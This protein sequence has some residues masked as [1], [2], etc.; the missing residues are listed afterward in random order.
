MPSNFVERQQLQF[1]NAI[2]PDFTK[3]CR[4]FIA[5]KHFGGY[6]ELESSLKGGILLGVLGAANV[7]LKSE[8]PNMRA[9]EISARRNTMI[10]DPYVEESLVL[11]SILKESGPL[12]LPNTIDNLYSLE[13]D[14]TFSFVY[15]ECNKPYVNKPDD[16]LLYT[17]PRPRDS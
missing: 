11:R 17:S 6:E 7:E 16:S 12:E 8:S 3:L 4:I 14:G 15:S 1:D 9:K 13:S 10:P 2:F 5:G